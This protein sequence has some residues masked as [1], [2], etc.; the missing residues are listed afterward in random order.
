MLRADTDNVVLQRTGKN[1]VLLDFRSGAYFQVNETA[2][3]IWKMLAQSA[4]SQRQIVDALLERYSARRE[5]VNKD[6]SHLLRT[7]KKSGLVVDSL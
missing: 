6:V 4:T 1:S 7:W 2:V 5:L 3:V